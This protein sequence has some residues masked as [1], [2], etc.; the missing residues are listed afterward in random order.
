MYNKYRN[1]IVDYILIGLIYLYLK[2]KIEMDIN[3]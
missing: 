3:K 1:Q 2:N